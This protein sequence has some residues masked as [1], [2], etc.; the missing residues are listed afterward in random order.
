M[1]FADNPASQAVSRALGYLED[2][3]EIHSPRGTPA[4]ALT[5]L[6]ERERWMQSDRPAVDVE[7]L[8]ECLPMFGI[9]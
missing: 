2:G 9:D 3:T 4:T 8:D 6:L 5:F 1:S 7:G